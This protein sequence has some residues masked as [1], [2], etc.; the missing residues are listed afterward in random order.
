MMK[1]A[2]PEDAFEYRFMFDLTANTFLQKLIPKRVMDR[3]FNLTPGEYFRSLLVL[4]YASTVFDGG[5]KLLDNVE[6][7]SK[8]LTKLNRKATLPMGLLVTEIALFAAEQ[9]LAAD[10]KRFVALD[11]KCACDV[12]TLDPYYEAI[13]FMLGDQLAMKE[14][15]AR[16]AS[17]GEYQAAV[18]ADAFLPHMKKGGDA[19]AAR[20]LKGEYWQASVDALKSCSKTLTLADLESYF[21]N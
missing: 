2:A 3:K 16:V 8:E 6:V 21:Q 15:A 17:K 4:S 19:V 12:K 5:A 1:C 18:F 14:G 10:R 20:L 13:G 11:T 9:D 7:L